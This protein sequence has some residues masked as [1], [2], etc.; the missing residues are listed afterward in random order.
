MTVLHDDP[1]I[2]AVQI[3]FLVLAVV[4]AVG[5]VAYEQ[6]GV[7]TQRRSAELSHHQRVAAQLQELQGTIA[8]VGSGNRRAPASVQIQLGTQYSSR[9][10]LGG[11]HAA[12]GRLRTIGIANGTAHAT[13]SNV[14]TPGETGDFLDGSRHYPTGMLV[15]QP[16]YNYYHSAPTTVYE[17]GILYQHWAGNHTQPTS[18]SSG[19][20][21]AV[22]STVLNARPLVSGRTIRLV[23][24]GGDLRRQSAGSTAVRVAPTSVSTRTVPIHNRDGHAITISLPTRLTRAR[25]IRLLRNQTKSYGGHVVGIHVRSVPD[26]PFDRA[27]LTLEPGVTYRLS[28]AHVSLGNA[29][30]THARYLTPVRGANAT[31]QEGRTRR[32][33]LE[34]RDRYNNPVSGVRVAAAGN[35]T[36]HVVRTNDRGDATFVY[37]APA[38]ID[39]GLRSVP[40]HFSIVRN[41]AGAE[42]FDATTPTNATVTL[43]VRN[44]DGSRNATGTHG[45]YDL[46]MDLPKVLGTCDLRC[47]WDLGQSRDGPPNEFV[48]DAHVG[49]RRY[50]NLGV[51]FSVNDTSLA[52]VSQ[53]PSNR[54]DADGRVSTRLIAHGTGVIELRATVEGR[55]ETATIELV[56]ASDRVESPTFRLVDGSA[57]V[58]EGHTGQA[59][60]TIENTSPN[61][62]D[63]AELGLVSVSDE[64]VAGIQHWSFHDGRWEDEVNVSVESDS[65][66]YPPDGTLEVA[67]MWRVGSSAQF[68]Q[69]PTMDPGDRATFYVTQFVDANG[70]PVDVRGDTVRLELRFQTAT[71]WRGSQTMN[72]TFG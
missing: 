33:T 45:V 51:E 56:N 58:R 28:V 26:R 66:T 38:N 31:V 1:R 5:V 60:F 20:L 16:G 12:T 19:A 15:Y 39:G 54:L 42:A 23:T 41:P 53:R 61:R 34:V 71:L 49:A 70:D 29:T 22:H 10:L 69:Y 68:R 3:G 64:R 35:V 44:T 14:R 62:L 9:S 37:T 50:E 32:V 6:F 55:T 65:L 43:H 7:T 36:R 24:L 47:T 40:L 46:S 57:H 67:A 27:V 17:N 2:R 63:L 59:M 48:V 52:T 11:D 72:V 4:G 25:W 13:V 30:A 21:G 8:R 18:Q